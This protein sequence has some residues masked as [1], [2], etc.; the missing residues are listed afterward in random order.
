MT[1]RLLQACEDLKSDLS[2]GLNGIV[3]IAA[4]SELASSF[5]PE[6]RRRASES[7]LSE[8]DAI[9]LLRA[10]GLCNMYDLSSQIIAS[11]AS[12]MTS[13]QSHRRLLTSAWLA[14]LE[15][16]EQERINIRREIQEMLTL[17]AADT[18]KV[19]TWLRANNMNFDL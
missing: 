5:V 1:E 6:I 19:N 9:V 13:A 8:D 18:R 2:K 12:R 3:A 11:V 7:E 17:H 14:Y 10:A 15:A 16:P 4:F